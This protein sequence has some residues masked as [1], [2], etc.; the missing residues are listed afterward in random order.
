MS[1][2]ALFFPLGSAARR[3][4]LLRTGEDRFGTAIFRLADAL[5]ELCPDAAAQVLGPASELARFDGARAAETLFLSA[6]LFLAQASGSTCLDLAPASLDAALARLGARP[7]EIASIRALLADRSPL[8]GG[9]RDRAPLIVEGGHLY[10]ERMFRSEVEL[11][12]RLGARLEGMAPSLGAGAAEALPEL[13]GVQLN[14]AQRRALERVLFAVR[15][16]KGGIVLITGGPGT[17]KTFVVAALL[18][19]LVR[20]GLPALPQAAGALLSRVAFA[21]PTGKAADR[22]GQSIGRALEAGLRAEGADAGGQSPEREILDALRSEGARPRTIHRLLGY[23]P[24]RDKFRHHAKN[25]LDVD[26][27][28]VD[29][30][31]MIDLAMMRRLLDALPH[32]SVLVLLGDADQL[33][34]VDAGAVLRDL[35]SSEDARLRASTVALVESRRQRADDPAGRAIL[36]AAQAINRGELA[37]KGVLIERAS[38]ADIAFQGAEHL[39]ADLPQIL[40]RWFEA[41]FACDAFAARVRREYRMAERSGGLAH[42]SAEDVAH[43]EALFAEVQRRKILCVTRAQLAAL[44][45]WFH[46][47][48]ARDGRLFASADAGLGR[49]FVPG[50][51][52][53]MCVNDTSRGLFN[54]DQGIVLRVAEPRGTQSFQAVFAGALGFRAFPLHE[55]RDDLEHAFAMTVHKSQGSEFDSVLFVLPAQDTPLLTREIA[56]TALT[57]ARRSAVIQGPRALLLEGVRRRAE[58]TS[59]LAAR[60]ARG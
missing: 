58:R 11:A 52:V 57:R 40:W 5:G 8:I 6:A 36:A 60:I 34:S 37:G 31:S 46:E 22:M 10:A 30:A 32:R 23:Q 49:A 41:P 56:Y 17:G 29:E 7:Q 12:D 1:S 35:V 19:A 28:V 38:A 20:S 50:E 51:P 48:H 44:N 4:G 26:V 14:S 39:G 16:G 27:L 59:G 33:P 55:L 42:F 13:P 47:R 2:D 9:P 54:G 15:G 25:P 21:A 53:M 18:R 43:L 24:A 45:G 3:A